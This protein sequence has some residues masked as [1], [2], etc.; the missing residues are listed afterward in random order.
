MGSSC[1]TNERRDLV[2][3]GNYC[4]NRCFEGLGECGASEFGEEKSVLMC[5]LRPEL[6]SKIID[7]ATVQIR[8][9]ITLSVREGREVFLYTPDMFNK[10]Y[11]DAVLKKLLPN[12]NAYIAVNACV[13]SFIESGWDFESLKSLG[14]KEIWFGVESGSKKLRDKYNKP[15]FDNSNIERLTV[16][17]RDAGVN[18]CW[19]LVDGDLDTDGTRLETF[20][21]LKEAQPFRFHF[22]PLRK[23]A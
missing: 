21:L 9:A 1:Y 6:D 11:R 10:F 14:I 19:F 7:N 18:I 4:S 16:L 5:E 15:N 3:V 13:H 12:P 22:S 20:T 2:I 23:A 8:A 17:G